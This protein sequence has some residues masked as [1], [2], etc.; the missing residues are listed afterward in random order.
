MAV[1]GGNTIKPL[2]CYLEGVLEAMNIVIVPRRTRLVMSA[3]LRSV[4]LD[5]HTSFRG[6]RVMYTC[7]SVFMLF[8][9]KI[10]NGVLKCSVTL[11][12]ITYS[13]R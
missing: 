12:T 2:E 11:D 7:G 5:Y 9:I 6:L 4:T 3:R 1:N 8:E 10:L 13:S